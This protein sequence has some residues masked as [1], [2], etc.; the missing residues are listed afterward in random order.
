MNRLGNCHNQYQDLI[1]FPRTLC[2]CSAGMLRSPTTAWIVS[3]PPYNRNSR[4]AGIVKEY[5]LIPV[6]MCLL[7]WAD[8]I[9]CVE[10]EHYDNVR[11]MLDEYE[12]K[13]KI[14]YCLNVP[15]EFKYR[16]ARLIKMIEYQ[17]KEVKFPE[18]QGK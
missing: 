2:V 6:D 17:L 10:E 13:N 8:E 5:A 3:N 16:D 7:E 15:D 9:I 4:A 18:Y 14:I 11:K 12:M 1:A